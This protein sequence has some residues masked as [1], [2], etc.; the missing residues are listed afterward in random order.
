MNAPRLAGT[1]K[2]TSQIDIAMSQQSVWEIMA[3]FPNVYTWAPAVEQS[4]SLTSA[5]TDIGAGRY[6]KL[7]GFGEIEEYITVW[8][9]AEG[10]VYN[11]TPLGPLH[12][13]FSSWWLSKVSENVTRLEVVFSYDIRFGLFG[14]MM[15]KLVMRKKLEQSLPETLRAFKNRVETGTLVR[16]LLKQLSAV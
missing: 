7:E 13:A 12:K 9:E 10:F 8:Q 4:R 3:D 16:P 2:V 15:H 5:Q 14:S 1:Y 6:C 11:V